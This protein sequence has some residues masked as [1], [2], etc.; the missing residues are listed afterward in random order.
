MA[1]SSVGSAQRSAFALAD[2]RTAIESANVVKFTNPWDA[3]T[4]DAPT[5]YDVVVEDAQLVEAEAGGD[6][7][8]VLQM[9]ESSYV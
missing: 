7:F 9:R 2:L 1:S 3:D 6:P 5:D 8:V 4:Y